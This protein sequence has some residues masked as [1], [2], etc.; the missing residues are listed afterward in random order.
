MKNG[1]LQNL[2]TV[3]SAVFAVGVLWARISHNAEAMRE[4]MIEI[5]AEQREIRKMI[6]TLALKP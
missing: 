2:I 3:L 5:Q 6:E 4:T 1:S